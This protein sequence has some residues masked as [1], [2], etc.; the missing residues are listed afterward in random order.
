MLHFQQCTDLTCY[1]NR[2]KITHPSSLLHYLLTNCFDLVFVSQV[3]CLFYV[4]CVLYLHSRCPSV[5]PYTFPTFFVF[6]VR[7][8][9]LQTA[10]IRHIS[11]LYVKIISLYIRYTRNLIVFRIKKVPPFVCSFSDLCA[12]IFN[13][14]LSIGPLNIELAK[15][16]RTIEVFRIF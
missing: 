5:S 11:I 15:Q 6:K 9:H 12:N 1:Y 2:F 13:I 14:E 3:D 4:S 10:H 16:P 7:P 8:S